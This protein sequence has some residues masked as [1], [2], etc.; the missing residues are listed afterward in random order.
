MEY[1]SQEAVY[2]SFFEELDEAVQI[3]YDFYMRGGAVV[4]LAS[5]MVYEGD[6][7]KWIRFANSLMLRLAIRVRYADEELARKYAEM[8]VTNRWA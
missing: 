8:A 1:D 6:V 5:D 3:L 2:H 4:P 7:A